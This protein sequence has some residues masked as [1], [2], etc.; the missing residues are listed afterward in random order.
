MNKKRWIIGIAAVLLTVFAVKRIAWYRWSHLSIEEK[1]GKITEKMA[2]RFHLTQEQK[3]KV[4]A[5]NLEKIQTFETA[6]NSGHRDRA[7]WKQLRQT[8]K[9]GLREVL[10]PEQQQKMRH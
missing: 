10:T 8:W 9:D 2:S 7:Q 4:Y 1:A 6:R 3:G 5:L